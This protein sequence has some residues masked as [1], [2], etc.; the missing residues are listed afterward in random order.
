MNQETLYATN[1]EYL[2]LLD[3]NAG[4]QVL[5]MPEKG[6]FLRKVMVFEHKYLSKNENSKILFFGGN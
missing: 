6:H 1:A 3:Q 4:F 5:S 2:D